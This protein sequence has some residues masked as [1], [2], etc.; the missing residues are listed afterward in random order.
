MLSC[1]SFS[2][3]TALVFAS[4]LMALMGKSTTPVSVTRRELRALCHEVRLGLLSQL[5]FPLW[6]VQSWCKHL[7]LSLTIL[8]EHATCLCAWLPW[9]NQDGYCYLLEKKYHIK[10]LSVF[11][12]NTLSWKYQISHIC[13]RMSRNAGIVLELRN[14]LPLVQLKQL[15]HIIL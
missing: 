14:Y 11:L 6:C 10:Y 7:G 13:S 9:Q 8:R 1:H 15:I 12:D 5:R 4:S 3:S 2:R